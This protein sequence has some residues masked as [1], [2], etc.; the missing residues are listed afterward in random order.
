MPAHL[1]LLE[2]QFTF[3]PNSKHL[4]AS[5]PVPAREAI[6]VPSN[7]PASACQR[8]STRYNSR[9]PPILRIHASAPLPVRDTIRDPLQMKN[10]F[11]PAH[12][13][14]HEKQFAFP[15]IPPIH[16]GDA[17][18]PAQVTLHISS[19]LTF[20]MP[21]HQLLHEKQCAFP[22]KPSCLSSC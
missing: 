2:I 5:E 20:L 12:L 19:Q 11:M 7:S 17:P 13:F 22:S 15:P 8:T 1:L 10:I 6:R 4:H 3:L 16:H 14:L 21:A 18:S 9:F